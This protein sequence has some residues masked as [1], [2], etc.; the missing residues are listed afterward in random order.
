MGG[1]PELKLHGFTGLLMTSTDEKGRIEVA[2]CDRCPVET[3]TIAVDLSQTKPGLCTG[4][5]NQAKKRHNKRY[6]PLVA[7]A[8]ARVNL[9]DAKRQAQD[10]VRRS[11]AA[12]AKDK[13]LQQEAKSAKLSPRPWLY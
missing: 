6:H 7:P 3:H 9:G 12:A 10:E 11:K 1:R 2:L 5:I 4:R 13:E 8:P